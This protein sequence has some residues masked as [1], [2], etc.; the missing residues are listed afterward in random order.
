MAGSFAQ[1]GGR[2]LLTQERAVPVG[3]IAVLVL[4]DEAAFSLDRRVVPSMQQQGV[5]ERLTLEKNLANR[6]YWES[7]WKTSGGRETISPSLLSDPTTAWIAGAIRA[8]LA[9]GRRFLEVGVGG[10]PWPA[11]VAREHGAEAW[12]IDFSRTGLETVER[13]PGSQHLIKL[14]EGDFFNS[15]K[16]PKASFDVVYSGG[17]VEHFPDC[18]PFMKRVAELLAPDGIVV[19]SVPNLCGVNGTLQKLLDRETYDRHL[20]ISPER[21]D[22]MHATGGFAQI[23]PAKFVGVIDLGAVNYAVW[24]E[25]VPGLL[26]KVIDYSLAKLRRAGALTYQRTHRH[27]NRWIAPMVGGVYAR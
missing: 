16:L 8:R 5:Q 12:G 27:G 26:W 13:V 15:P 3:E 11:H 22:E 1:S 2:F 20:V 17:F 23:E 19:T 10:S 21:L 7:V 18:R 14:I 24:A 9:P 4:R 25:R 6:T